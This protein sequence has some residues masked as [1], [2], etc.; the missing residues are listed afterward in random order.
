MEKQDSEINDNNGK[1]K[2]IDPHT[3]LDIIIKKAEKSFPYFLEHIFPQSFT[4][5]DIVRSPHTWKWAERI[6]NN[7]HTAT[8]SARK[9]LK[10]TTMYAW[11]MWKLFKMNSSNKPESGLYMSY[12][13]KMSAYHTE[14]IK[15]LIES[16]PMFTGME[17]LTRGST[18]ID[19]NF[20]GHRFTVEPSGIL[21][22]N[23]GWHGDWVVCDDI[24]QDPTSELVFTIIDKINRIFMESV[25]SL[26]KEGG[27]LH[28]CGTAQHTQDLFFKL[29]ED[30]SWNWAQYKAIINEAE[31]K[32]LWPELFSIERLK[33][34]RGQIGDKAFNKEYMCSPVWSE[35][36]YFN[37]EELMSVVDPNID[38]LNTPAREWKDVGRVVAGL[39]IGKKAHPSHISI[40]RERDGMYT[41][42]YQKF[43]DRWD[44]TRQVEYIKQLVD[45]YLIDELR[46]DNTRGELEPFAEQNIINKRIWK[47]V[48]FGTKNKFEM[49]SNFTRHVNNKDAEGNPN[50]KIK[51][52][53]NQRMIDSILSVNNDLKAPETDLGH[54]DCFWSIGLA[55]YQPPKI[56]GYV[57]R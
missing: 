27:E 41:M 13:Q 5:D 48:S 18:K 12:N 28:L 26:P 39:D 55:L 24:L 10:S 35:D 33:Q 44:Y 22:F 34:I 15:W 23:R 56:R 29:K 2:D 54:G 43:F 9:H 50:P 4:G 53:N 19:Y 38:T 3:E 51:L 52:L 8:L 1:T 16:N 57:S 11:V 32:T 14:N 42:I 21:T 7:K 45:Y 6:Q 47:P 49:A 31:G 46:Y 30:D 25:M 40:F 37:R 20:K 17:D 36:A